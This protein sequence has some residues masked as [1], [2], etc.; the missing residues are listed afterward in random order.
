[1]HL[2]GFLSTLLEMSNKS[3][4]WKTS[5][6]IPLKHYTAQSQLHHL[7]V[8]LRQVSSWPMFPII[9][10]NNKMPCP[11]QKLPLPVLP[12]NLVQWHI[13]TGGENGQI[14]VVEVMSGKRNNH[15]VK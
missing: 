14:T 10:A 7:L 6:A 3:V 4:P 11:F 1:M 13:H 2:L 12:Y 8:D 9:M 5:L 15:S